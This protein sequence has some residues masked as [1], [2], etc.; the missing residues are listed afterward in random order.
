MIRFRLRRA[1]RVE[2]VVRADGSPCVVVG[3][4]RVRGHS[5]VNQVPF[6]GR[7]HGRPLAPGR[8]TITVVVVRGGRRARV[9]TVGVEV[10]S[11]GRRLTRSQQ[12]APVATSCPGASGPSAAAT[13]LIALAAPLATG[14]ITSE[15]R[16]HGKRTPSPGTLGP[17]LR[18]PRLPRAV[19]DA[20]GGFAWAGALVYAAIGL[21]GAVMLVQVARFFRGSWNP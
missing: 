1:A 13:T 17:S 8:Y 5:G 11:S 14:G 18:P 6:D 7:L 12:T 2:L 20:G 19:A 21:A 16:T 3:R 10:V 9:G 4:R 15:A